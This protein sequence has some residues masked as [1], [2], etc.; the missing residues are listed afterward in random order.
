MLYCQILASFWDLDDVVWTEKWIFVL[1]DLRNSFLDCAWNQVETVVLHHEPILVNSFLE[2]GLCDNFFISPDFGIEL[3]IKKS[4]L[5]TQ[6]VPFVDFR[7]TLPLVLLP[8]LVLLFG[9]FLPIIIILSI[10]SINSRTDYT[11]FKPFTHFEVGVSLR[12]IRD[13]VDDEIG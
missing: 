13:D 1:D 7:N 11:V 12:V 8:F 10:E 6:D 4:I 2:Q 5:T 9:S 3:F